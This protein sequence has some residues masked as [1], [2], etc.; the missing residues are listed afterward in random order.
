MNYIEL[1]KKRYSVRAFNS[2]KIENS[3]KDLIL[4]AARIAPTGMNTQPFRILVIESK[5]NLEKLTKIARIYAAPLVFIICTNKEEAWIRKYDH[6]SIEDIDA[7]IVTDHMMMEAT[8]L[9]LGSLWICHF[10]PNL[11][12][13]E[14]NIPANL[15]PLN[16]LAVGYTDKSPQ[17]PDR[18][19]VKRKTISE[20]VYYETF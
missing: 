11:V 10:N 13:S 18:H 20:L 9:G 16:M 3:K 8:D 2:E 14:F 6:K 7:S 17:S 5:Q 15:Q 4:E 1:A 12:K 19:T